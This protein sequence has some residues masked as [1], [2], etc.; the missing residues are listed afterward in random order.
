MKE[1]RKCIPIK[2][3]R[4][5]L[6]HDRRIKVLQFKR[7]M[8]PLQVKNVIQRG[9]SHIT[10]SSFFFLE[11]TSNNLS[12]ARN[13]QIDGAAVID[14]RGALYLCEVALILAIFTAVLFLI[15]CPK[16]KWCNVMS[17]VPDHATSPCMHAHEVVNLALAVTI[18]GLR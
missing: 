4:C 5:D 9:F 15:Y 11:T 2:K 8:S 13:Q 7:S 16:I 10:F 17:H 1:F 18:R 3:Y 12:I 6:K 14:R